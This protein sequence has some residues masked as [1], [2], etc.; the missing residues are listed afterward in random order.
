MSLDAPANGRE[1]ILLTANSLVNGDRNRDYD[2]PI[3][4]FGRISA[5]WNVYLD[6]IN[7]RL[8][9]PHDVALL[10]VL[11]KIARLQHSK[12]HRDSWVD[13]AGYAG[14]GWD[15]LWSP[16]PPLAASMALVSDPS[17]LAEVVPPHDGFG[18][19]MTS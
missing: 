18:L 4:N 12:D 1:D 11:Q 3:D 14:C 10:N 15:C 5:F 6:G 8:L 19:P 7:R 13:I 2:D 16:E 17:G 9:E